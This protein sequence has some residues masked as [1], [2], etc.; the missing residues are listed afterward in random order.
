MEKGVKNTKEFTSQHM[1]LP[2]SS[3]LSLHAVLFHLF[4]YVIEIEEFFLSPFFLPLVQNVLCLKPAVFLSIFGISNVY[5][6]NVNTAFTF[7][8]IMFSS[9]LTVF[10]FKCTEIEEAMRKKSFTSFKD[11]NKKSN[12]NCCHSHM[13]VEHTY[14]NVHERHF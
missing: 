6:L 3:S 7:M 5:E 14:E 13:C 12:C 10:P 9:T 11:S 4:F 8:L 2:R 1:L